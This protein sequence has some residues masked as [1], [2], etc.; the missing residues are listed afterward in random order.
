M[1]KRKN[2][3]PDH[4]RLAEAAIKVRKSFTGNIANDWPGRK[5][6]WKKRGGRR[7]DEERREEESEKEE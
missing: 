1:S 4:T 5:P 3:H 2:V 6:A 7:R